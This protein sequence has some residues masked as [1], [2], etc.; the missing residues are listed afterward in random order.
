M[1]RRCQQVIA[2]LQEALT[3]CVPGLM[4]HPM[5]AK[6]M[7]RLLIG[8]ASESVLWFRPDGPVDLMALARLL[9]GQALLTARA[10]VERVWLAPEPVPSPA[11][12]LPAPWGDRP[13]DAA[14]PTPGKPRG[15][16][17][18]LTAAARQRWWQALDAVEAGAEVIVT[19]RDWP[20]LKLQP[21]T[22][23]AAL[24]RR[25]HGKA[26]PG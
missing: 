24:A 22:A 17:L 12:T 20:A 18:W 2:T 16:V 21:A 25:V 8:S 3:A 4:D 19:R 11:P 10:I 7:L 23:E 15:E 5:A 9:A 26:A 6:L 1:Q 14:P 13:P